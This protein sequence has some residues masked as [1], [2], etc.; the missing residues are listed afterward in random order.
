MA[1]I[2]TSVSTSGIYSTMQMSDSF[3][4]EIYCLGPVSIITVGAGTVYV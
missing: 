1:L 4:L 3:V 2:K